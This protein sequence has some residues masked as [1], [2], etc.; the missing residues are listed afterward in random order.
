MLT[1]AELGRYLQQARKHVRLSQ[2]AVATQLGVT[3]QVVSAFESGKRPV[4]S[5]ELQVLC[6][7]FRVYPNDLLGFATDLKED[8]LS[9][10]LDF[11]MNR[12]IFELSE[13]DRREV[14]Y[15]DDSISPDGKAY[16]LRWNKSFK[17]YSADRK[18]PFWSM[19]ELA[20]NLRNGLGQ[21]EPPINIYL[22]TDLLGIYVKPTFLDKAAAIVN[23]AN[24]SLEAPPWIL[25]SSS[26]PVDRQ[27]YSIAHEIAHL[28]LHE[29]DLLTHHPH[30]YRRHFDQREID[31]E[32]F[33]AELLMPQDLIRNSV[34]KLRTKEPVEEAAFLLSY[35]YQV[36]FT[37]ISKRLYELNLITRAIYNHLTTVK[38]SKLEGAAKKFVVK[39]PFKP[40]KFIP[41]ITD[42]LGISP[43]PQAFD[44]K[45]VRRMQEM[46]YTR[47]LGLQTRGGSDPKAL[48]ALE[49]PGR[50]YEKVALWI[51]L[52][53]P[54][55]KSSLSQHPIIV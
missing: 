36:S 12:G 34:T 17:Q 25:V 52:R 53:Y 9:R 30:Y 33:A 24:E 16:F 39:Y 14:G 55:N 38:P 26:Q 15:M 22:M 45:A 46:A 49:S 50:V 27:R 2:T 37:A 28:L 48:Y 44:P 19:P 5:G 4:S 6:N 1:Y 31:A 41:G 11:R 40:E 54:M 47:Y 8:S 29:E 7:L 42:E 23:R 43:T 32:S 35:I 10:S 18:K 21:V 13:N 20:Q 51:A 3:R